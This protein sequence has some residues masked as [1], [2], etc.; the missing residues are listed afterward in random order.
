[1]TKNKQNNYQNYA[2]SIKKY[3]DKTSNSLCLITKDNIE[4]K[5]IYN[6][7]SFLIKNNLIHI[8]PENDIL[9]YDHFSIPED[10]TKQRFQLI[11][12][13]NKDKHILIS[14]VKNLFEIFPDRYF[15]KSEKTFS[16]NDELSI[17][18][19]IKIVESLNYQKITNVEKINEY[20]VRGGIID[21]FSPIYKSPLRIEIF[22]DHIESIRLFD[23]ESQL[24]IKNINQFSISK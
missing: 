6:E 11:N 3:F 10:I 13:K 14:S 8:F 20:S 1:M 4:S 17:D 7:L 19:I 23:I 22:D 5:Y 9:P 24:S 18:R 15:F 12:N 21:V 2:Y 16:I